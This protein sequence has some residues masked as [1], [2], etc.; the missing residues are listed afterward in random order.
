M[1]RPFDILC[2]KLKS[3]VG[4]KYSKRERKFGYIYL[5][6]ENRKFGKKWGG[7]KKSRKK[8]EEEG[9]F[10]FAFAFVE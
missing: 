7:R 5:S 2:C 6:N 9:V 1:V 4:S 10:A 3:M 8:E